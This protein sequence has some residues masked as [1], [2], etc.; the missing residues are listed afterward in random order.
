[1]LPFS[2]K[3]ITKKHH[4]AILWCNYSTYCIAVLCRRYSFFPSSSPPPRA[5]Q[6]VSVEEYEHL[7]KRPEKGLLGGDNLSHGSRPYRRADLTPVTPHATAVTPRAPRLRAVPSPNRL[8]AVATGRSSR[9]GSETPPAMR[10]PLS[11]ASGEAGCG[12]R[13]GR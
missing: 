1:M 11:A 12:R 10:S 9:H 7:R 6:N 4:T 8:E 2:K 3:Q 13:T 5:Y